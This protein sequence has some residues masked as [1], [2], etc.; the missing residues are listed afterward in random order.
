MHGK[1]PF[2]WPQQLPQLTLH[3]EP[4]QRISPHLLE[5]AADPSQRRSMPKIGHGHPPGQPAEAGS[6]IAMLLRQR[7]SQGSL[8]IQLHDEDPLI[9]CLRLDASNE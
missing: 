2:P 9:P 7:H 1:R 5:R 8:A 4:E 6:G 3:E